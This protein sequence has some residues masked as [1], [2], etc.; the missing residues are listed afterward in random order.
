[1]SWS[2]SV[3]ESVR[4][5]GR[6]VSGYTRV[7]CPAC[8]DRVGKVDRKRSVSVNLGNGFWRCWRCDARGRLPGDWEDGWEDDEGWE[9][10]ESEIEEPSDYT[11]IS[12]HP[13]LRP[14]TRFLNRRGV[15]PELWTQARLGYAREGAHRHR[16]IMPIWDAGGDWIGWVGRDVTGRR[17]PPY[18]T[19]AGTDRRR[20]FYNDIALAQTTDVPLLVTEGPIDALRH[21]PNASAALG[22]P[23]PDHVERLRACPRPLIIALDGDAWREGLG[24]AQ[25]LRI[26]RPAFALRLPHAEDLDSTDPDLVRAGVRYAVDH[27][28]DVDLTAR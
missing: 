26:D 25:S 8:P 11:P 18:H 7:N 24:I 2:T 17:L 1:V 15:P 4:E 3:E 21:W 16:V 9:D 22:K 12:D 5:S 13:K 28:C 19:A 23:T 20:V 10:I 6:G 14:A 27:G